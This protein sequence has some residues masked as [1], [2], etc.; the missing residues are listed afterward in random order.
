MSKSKKKYSA[1][2]FPASVLLRPR[3]D[4]LWNKSD[5]SQQSDAAIIAELDEITRG[6]K[7]DLLLPTLIRSCLAAPVTNRAR[8]DTILPNWLQSQNH[9]AV[10]AQLIAQEKLPYELRGQASAWLE[11]SGTRSEPPSPAPVSTDL[12]YQAY[13]LDDK[14]QALV[15]VLWYVDAKKQRV[16]G[17]NFLIDYNPPWNGAVKDVMLY[18][19]LDQRDVKWKYIDIWKERGQTLK[20]I[21]GAAA[22]TKILKCLEQNRKNKIR[23][24]RDLINNRDAF[25]HFVL[26]LPDERITPKFTDD[27]WQGLTKQ[28][29]SADDIARY[30]QTVGRRVRM[31]NGKE[32]LIMGNLDDLDGEF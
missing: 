9:T 28:G 16:Y 1:P 24:S 27:D 6:V 7:L 5:L 20:P 14:S 22:K 2:N 23:L 11:A 17:M 21:S 30:E 31:E 15:V 4:A 18:P 10:L 12:F 19:K 13:D 26:A 3:L 32:I 29:Q 8:Q 25:W